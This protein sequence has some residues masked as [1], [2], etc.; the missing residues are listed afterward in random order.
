M[1]K[2]YVVQDKY[3]QKAKEQGYRARS[4]FKLLE[5]NEKF[6]IFKKGQK[7]LD[8]GSA[9][10][11]W[12]Q[13][14]SQKIKTSNDQ[15]TKTVIVGIDLQ[16]IEALPGVQLYQADITDL[17][18]LKELLGHDKFDVITAD[19]APKTSGIKD[20]DQYRSVEL[21]LA[22]LEV[23]KLFLKPKG[24]LISK[25]F[26]G[27][28]FQDLLKELKQNFLKIRQHK[29]KATRDRSFETYLVCER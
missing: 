15:N 5:L 7:V 22:V 27:A 14:L 28:D 20:V 1:P 6:R 18:K 2:A 13:V 10:G 11:S 4:A 26:I 21:N 29:P 19:L 9:P 23:A 17:E 8:L 12:L 24:K 25:V 16:E 3:F